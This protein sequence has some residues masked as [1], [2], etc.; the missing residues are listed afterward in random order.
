MKYMIITTKNKHDIMQMRK[1]IKAHNM[2]FVMYA[3]NVAPISSM[4]VW[5][6]VTFVEVINE[7]PS[8]NGTF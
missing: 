7:I 6:W 4:Q 3:H 5:Q 2:S 8:T 1:I